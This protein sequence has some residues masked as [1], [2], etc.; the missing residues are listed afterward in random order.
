EQATN[1][2]SLFTE[3][4]KLRPVPTK[5]TLRSHTTSSWF[6]I[7]KEKHS[8]ETLPLQLFSIGPKF[9]REQKLDARH[10]YESWTA[11]IVVMAEEISLEDG[12]K[13][14]EQIFNKLDFLKVELRIKKATSKYYAPKTEFEVFVKHPNTG[15]FIEVGDGGL[16]NPLSLAKY[17]IPYPVFNCG[18]GLER[19]AMVKTGVE[20]IRRLVYPILYVEAE[21]TDEQLAKMVRVDQTPSTR[22]GEKLVKAIIRTATKNASQQSPC[23]F[24]V[25]KGNFLGRSIEVYVYETE[26]GQKLLGPAALNNI[27]V[28]DGNVLGIPK[29]GMDDTEIVSRARKNGVF[30]KICYLDAIAALAVD[31]IEKKI[32]AKEVGRVDIRIKMAKLPSDVNVLIPAAGRSYITSK[33]KKIRVNGP[34]FVGIEANIV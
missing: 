26:K 4:N 5:L 13:I 17:N 22:E 25:Y 12:Q 21:F 14:V 15:R 6:P 1:I 16:Y 10:L 8:K 30:T 27:Y 29:E 24:L 23:Q 32:N 3:F 7:L 2:I 18:I 34:V 31:S 19:V 33:K 20:D 9:R 28:Y 11:S